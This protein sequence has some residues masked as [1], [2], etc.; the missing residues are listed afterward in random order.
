MLLHANSQ[1]AQAYG[2]QAGVDAFAHGMWTWNDRSKT[3]LNAEVT[4]ILD[5]SIE[6]GIAL[7][8]TIQVL[9]GERDLHDPDY[10]AGEDLRRVVPESLLEWYTT[11]DGQWWR[12]RMRRSSYV[13]DLIESGN[14]QM[15]DADPIARVRTVLGHW[16][17]N[18]GKLLFGSDT[19]S[20]PTYANPPGLNG[21]LEIDRWIAAGVSLHRILEA[22]TTAN[23]AFFSLHDVGS[24]SVGKRANIVLTSLN[25]LETA[26]AY[27]HIE[28]IV[29]DGN[30]MRRD[31]LSANRAT[32]PFGS[33]SAL[34]P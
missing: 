27:D 33:D 18:N 28:L 23:A 32:R 20:D 12:N 2:L 3:E 9:Y 26:A 6:R 7:Q 30:P 8:P 14:W 31:E 5:S 34:R 17:A 19:P 24:I 13:S 21:R 1:A 22:L 10:L 16:A 25:P 4:R 15:I 11:E 29:I